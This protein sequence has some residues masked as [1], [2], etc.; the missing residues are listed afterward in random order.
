VLKPMRWLALALLLGNLFYFGWELSRQTRADLQNAAVALPVPAGTARLALIGEA[1]APPPRAAAE[2]AGAGTVP[3]AV[4]DDELLV[5]RLPEISDLAPA[6][7]PVKFS[8]FSFGPLPD[9]RQ[10]VWLSDWFRARKASV[11]TRSSEESHQQ[12]YW[13][14]LAPQPSD[15]DTKAVLENLQRSGVRDYRL[16]SRG[17][18][19]NAV[20]LGLFSS[21]A[22]VNARIDELR[23]QGYQPVVVPYSDV[24][25]M[26]WLDVQVPA[27]PGILAQMFDG[28]PAR[29]NSVPVQCGEIAIDGRGQ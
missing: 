1:D 9:E 27:V 4:P 25:R 15:D 11:S 18:L 13:V 20:S 10:V 12:L 6:P 8:C 24:K 7:G 26:H 16:I 19:A 23:E 17:D 22:A 2:I 5:A 28:L 21:Q 14:Y 3:P 29:F